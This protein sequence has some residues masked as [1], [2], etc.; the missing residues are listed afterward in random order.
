MFNIIINEKHQVTEYGNDF[1]Q[2]VT[3][4]TLKVCKIMETKRFKKATS[5]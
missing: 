3:F 1:S 4:S 2:Q 5:S